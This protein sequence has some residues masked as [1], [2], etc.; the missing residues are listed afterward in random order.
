M[1]I[2][3]N[4]CTDRICDILKNVK[5][6]KD[7]IY[8][9]SCKRGKL[10][11][12]AEDEFAIAFSKNENAW[13][14][15]GDEGYPNTVPWYKPDFSPDTLESFFYIGNVFAVKGEALDK[16][17]SDISIYEMVLKI[18][19]NSKFCHV[20]KILFINNSDDESIKI[21]GFGMAE[22]QEYEKIDGE[23][24]VSVIIPSKDNSK[25]LK[26]CVSSFIEKTEYKNYEIIVVDNGSNNDDRLC[27]NN[28]SQKYGFKYIYEEQVFN[29]SKM[30]NIGAKEAKGDILLFLN[31]DIE[32]VDGKWLYN[33]L[34]SVVKTHVGAVGAKLY[35]PNYTIQHVGITN[36]GVGPVHKTGEYHGHC[37]ANYD[38]IAVTGACLMI[39]HALFDSIGGFDESFPIAY[40]DVELCFRLYRLGLYN[41]V[42]GDAVLIH[43]ES[44][45]RGSDTSPEKKKRLVVEKHRLYEK[46]PDMKNYDPFY[47]PNLV[48]WKWDSEYTENIIHEYD[49]GI[50]PVIIS[51]NKIKKLP[52]Q[53]KNK[54]IKKLTGEN[55][56]MFNIDG[57]DYIDSI[58]N[59]YNK[60]MILI[61]G[62]VTLRER[63]NSDSTCKKQLLLKSL[64][65]E[66]VI[67]KLDIQPKQREDV[68]GLFDNK[69]KNAA[70]SGI[71][72]F[73]D[74]GLIPSGK[75][76][77]GVLVENSR[78]FVKW[79][80]ET[81]ER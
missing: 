16:I 20:S 63:D 12:D 61:R 69:T 23:E 64:Q 44:L 13:L 29:F 34:L 31:D 59:M 3:F 71:N 55:L 5:I 68:A 40:N 8:I 36:M 57:V 79:S 14:A 58:E 49:K 32:V 51:Q 10:T 67:Y 72:V 22:S 75:Y 28:L 52:R 19:Q 56:L 33:M 4:D 30:C 11:E 2:T 24:F 39:K 26:K 80:T 43:H 35:Y 54:Y 17:T 50:T 76:I 42:R 74:E 62:W 45:S 1:E 25:V 6:V 81:I 41:M 66:S 53:H 70:N 21:P 37:V 18:A 15:Y 46:H 9:F 38:M 65:N 48:Q 27:I 73:F 77:I 7:N 60:N 47:S 78:R